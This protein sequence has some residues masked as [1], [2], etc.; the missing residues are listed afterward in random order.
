MKKVAGEGAKR[1]PLLETVAQL[2]HLARGLQLG[3]I[4]RQTSKG[5]SGNVY[6]FLGR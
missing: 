2:G 3:S 4:M 5:S 6:R 1:I